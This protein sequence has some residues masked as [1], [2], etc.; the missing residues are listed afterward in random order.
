MLRSR[1][2]VD[3]Y[4]TSRNFLSLCVF[5]EKFLRKCCQIFRCHFS[6][7]G[8]VEGLLYSSEVAAGDCMIAALKWPSGQVLEYMSATTKGMQDMGCH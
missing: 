5:W 8:G 4:H 3:L 6:K 1:L 2:E 7:N